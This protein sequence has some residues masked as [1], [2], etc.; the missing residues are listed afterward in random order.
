MSL[1]IVNPVIAPPSE[2]EPVE[3]LIRRVMDAH[4]GQSPREL[5]VYFEAVHQEIAPLARALELDNETLR[6]QVAERDQQFHDM[7]ML[8]AR[9]ATKLR[10]ADPKNDLVP[11]AMDYLDRK[12]Y[13]AQ[14]RK[15]VLR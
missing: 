6:H 8:I 12:G 5:A 1:K 2:H 3:D 11:K 9:L 10:K 13:T 4:P 15:N 7:G 14:A